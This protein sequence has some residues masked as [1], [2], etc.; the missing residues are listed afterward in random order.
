[1]SP[2]NKDQEW[3]SHFSEARVEFLALP[4]ANSVAFS[5]LPH[6]LEP[7]ILTGKD[8]VVRVGGKNRCDI[9]YKLFSK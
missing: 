9:G 5:M 7:H 4:F 2:S 6:C 1:M 3:V 8:Y